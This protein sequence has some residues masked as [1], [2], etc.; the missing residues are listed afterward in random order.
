MST[1]TNLLVDSLIFGGFLLAFEPRLTGI[2]VHEWFSLALA[3]T[4][5][6]HVALHWDWVVQVAT[7]FFRKLFHESRLNLALDLMLFLSFVLVMFS[8]ILIS[9]SVVN[10]LGLQLAESPAWRFLHAW[11]ANAC[12]I[13]TGLHV[14]LHWKWI[15]STVGRYVVLPLKKVRLLQARPEAQPVPVEV[16]KP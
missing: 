6:F 13:L 12:L 8:G 2:A 5:L 1:K 15:V 10:V 9:R 14:A 3:A 4:L 16:D 7:R 11:S